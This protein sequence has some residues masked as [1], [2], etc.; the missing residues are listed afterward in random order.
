MIL[1]YEFIKGWVNNHNYRLCFFWGD[2]LQGVH[3][4]L[5]NVVL[6]A[7]HGAPTVY[8]GKVCAFSPPAL[9]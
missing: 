4:S 6:G 9:A 8:L 7:L 1:S 2:A 3:R 5:S